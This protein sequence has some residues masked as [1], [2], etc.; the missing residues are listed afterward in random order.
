MT[1]TKHR[2]VGR[3]RV[4]FAVAEAFD[5]FT[6]LGERDWA[7]GWEP[8]FPTPVGDDTEPGTVFETD[9]H[10]QRTVWIVTGRERPHCISYARLTPGSR[11][12]TVTV[13]L[14]PAG[15]HTEVEV[16]Y[17]LTALTPSA[18]PE[19]Q[20]FADNYTAYLESWE[21]SISASLSHRA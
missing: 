10:G 7:H 8:H 16:T 12:G 1:A 4:P 20:R 13:L 15:A 18:V 2:L 3:L 5:L 14:E 21:H 17:E 9:A 19:L 6:P 11:A